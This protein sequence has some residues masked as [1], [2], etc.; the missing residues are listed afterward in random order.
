MKKILKFL[1]GAALA[2]TV[3]PYAYKKNEQT[4]EKTVKALLWKASV[5]PDS[6]LEGKKKFSLSIGFNSPFAD[7]EEEAIFYPAENEFFD[8]ESDFTPVC[9]CDCTNECAEVN[10]CHSEGDCCTAETAE[11]TVKE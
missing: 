7:T 6:E 2:A 5:R 9:E 3:I 10:E 1:G 11:E 8:D 4:E